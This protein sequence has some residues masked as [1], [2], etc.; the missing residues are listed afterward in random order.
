MFSVHVQVHK[1]HVYIVYC[2]IVPV[3]RERGRDAGLRSLGTRLDGDHPCAAIFNS[4]LCRRSIQDTQ[5]RGM[6]RCGGKNKG[7]MIRCSLGVLVSEL[8]S[9]KSLYVCIVACITCSGLT[10]SS[11]RI[12]YSKW[13][14]QKASSSTRALSCVSLSL[15]TLRQVESEPVLMNRVLSYDH[16][17]LPTR[18][19]KACTRLEM[20]GL[21]N[22]LGQFTDQRSA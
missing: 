9:G 17:L 5:T 18:I 15:T 14:N 22:F 21:G 6:C 2:V 19:C 4:P 8:W 7:I 3:W 13:A 1:G 20:A 10:R 16:R 11:T 12:T